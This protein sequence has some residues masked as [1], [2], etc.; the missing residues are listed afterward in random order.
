MSFRVNL[1]NRLWI[2]ELRLVSKR[3]PRADILQIEVLNVELQRIFPWLVGV[4]EQLRVLAANL[5]HQQRDLGLM[6]AA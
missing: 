3:P 5:A 4:D 6:F 1:S 2:D